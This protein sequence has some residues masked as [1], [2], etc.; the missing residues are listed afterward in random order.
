LIT[1][2]AKL[3]KKRLEPY[4]P[5]KEGKD[6]TYDYY[7]YQS[8][9]KDNEELVSYVKLDFEQQRLSIQKSQKEESKWLVQVKQIERELN[10]VWFKT[11]LQKKLT[12]I[13]KNL[14]EAR[15][16]LR[17]KTTAFSLVLYD[18]HEQANQSGQI[19]EVE[20]KQLKDFLQEYMA[21]A[22]EKVKE[23]L[24]L[25]RFEEQKSYEFKIEQVKTFIPTLDSWKSV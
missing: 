17:K 19:K 23:L 20:K 24:D 15:E 11:D 3:S 25:E 1:S 8:W 7:D 6:F 22:D 21:L 9:R 16:K 12:N 4:K 13:E 5:Y 14:S 18:K 10:K 2:V